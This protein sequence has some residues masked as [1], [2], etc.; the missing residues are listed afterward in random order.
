VLDGC[1][2]LLELGSLLWVSA[3]PGSSTS[4]INALCNEPAA[5]VAAEPYGNALAL[6]GV[7]R[8]KL[9]VLRTTP[10]ITLGV[11]Q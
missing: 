1:A 3:M 4:A 2:A 10:L 11:Q 8:C 7:L 6:P 5:E 9:S